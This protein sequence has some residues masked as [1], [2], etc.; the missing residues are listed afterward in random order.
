M[1]RVGDLVRVDTNEAALDP[2]E[3][4]V[5]VLWCKRRLLAKGLRQQWRQVGDEAGVAA[6][7]HLERQ[8]LA[9]VQGHRPCFSDR[10]PQPFAWQV[11]FV[12]AVS[13]FVHGAHQGA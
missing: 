8:G 12:A 9:F 4:A 5:Q 2:G 3:Q 11:L 6:E 1:R 10:L 13:R 7:L